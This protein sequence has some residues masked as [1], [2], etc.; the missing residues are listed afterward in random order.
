MAVAGF[1]INAGAPWGDKEL[2]A[3]YL[4]PF[5]ALFFTGPGMYSLDAK[6]AGSSRGRSKRI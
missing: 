2:A 1:V 4:V 6:I 5:A 3:I